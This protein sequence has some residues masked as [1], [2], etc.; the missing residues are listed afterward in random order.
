MDEVVQDT[1]IAATDEIGFREVFL[2]ENCWYALTLNEK[3]I[4]DIKYLAV[5]RKK[6]VSGVTHVA[7]VDRIE[8]YL[9]KYHKYIVYFKKG[10]I[11]ELPRPIGI[12]SPG[13]SIQCTKFT[14]YKKLFTANN[15]R[16]L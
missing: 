7:E 4:S 5:Y 6:P 10:S 16:E 1:I 8:N 9:G 2:G 15:T 11:V 14:S 12:V 3:R 13:D